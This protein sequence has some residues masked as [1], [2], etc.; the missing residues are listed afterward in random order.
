[1]EVDSFVEK[2]ELAVLAV[3]PSEDLS[4]G[5]CEGMVSSCADF[6]S[7]FHDQFEGMRVLPISESQCTILSLSTTKNLTSF[8]K[9]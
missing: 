5:E 1:M 3:A 2:S 9:Q 6:V 4:F 7:S 8:Q